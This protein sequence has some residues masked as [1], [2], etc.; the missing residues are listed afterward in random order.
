MCD[1][2]TVVKTHYTFSYL[3]FIQLENEKRTPQKHKSFP[4]KM[5]E[6]RK[7]KDREAESAE[8]NAKGLAAA[9]RSLAANRKGEVR[10]R[11]ERERERERESVCGRYD[12][13]VLIEPG[14]SFH[15]IPFYSIWGSVHVSRGLALVLYCCTLP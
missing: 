11:R 6:K 4:Q 10:E 8:R 14:I 15:S 3:K 13:G 7:K 2:Y 12:E 9:K 1:L 5:R